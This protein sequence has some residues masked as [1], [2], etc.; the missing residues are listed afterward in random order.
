MDATPADQD[1]L[2]STVLVGH[3]SR[4]RVLRVLEA[5]PDGSTVAEIAEGVGLQH[6][7]VRK[8]LRTLETAGLV[9]AAEARTGSIGRPAVR[10]E[11]V[12]P[13]PSG[14]AELARL[15]AGLVAE[16]GVTERQAEEFGRREGRMLV[17]AGAG[18][19]AVVDVL[20]RLGF[21]PAQRACEDGG[22]D[23]ELRRCAFLEAAVGPAGHLVC[24]LHR[25]LTAGMAERGLDGGRLIGFEILDPR[26][27]HC[28]AVI[29]AG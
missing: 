19:E 6:N 13:E 14:S 4:L 10:Y 15:L 2:T 1:A 8:Q 11:R 21:A 20:D 5:S 27:A 12:L 29:G 9:R 23:I 26:S 25:G 3:P 28:R 22:C 24:L 18:T 16:S 17:A 7:A